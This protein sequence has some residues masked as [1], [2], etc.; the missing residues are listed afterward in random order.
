MHDGVGF[1]R[2]DRVEDVAVRLGFGENEFCARVDGRAVTFRQVVIDG[3]LMA[4]VEQ[5]FGS[6]GPDVACPAGDEYVH[7]NSLKRFG[8][9]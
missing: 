4:G 2:P 9:F 3:D 8:Q 1:R 7:A 6:H 5:F